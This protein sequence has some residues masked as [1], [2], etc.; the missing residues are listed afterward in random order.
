[1]LEYRTIVCCLG[2]G[3]G[4]AQAIVRA[5]NWSF[6]TLDTK[7]WTTNSLNDWLFGYWDET[8]QDLHEGEFKKAL[9]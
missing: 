5:N 6:I 3:K 9:R 2:E 1:M 7:D 4:F 8:I